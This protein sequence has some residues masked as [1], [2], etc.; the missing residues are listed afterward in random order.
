M[1]KLTDDE[2]QHLT[3]LVASPQWDVVK[4]YLRRV[5]DGERDTLSSTNFENL[6]QVGRSQGRIAALQQL[7]RWVE[8]PSKQKGVS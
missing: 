5:I 6:L 8:A 2:R 1:S 4:S 3:N 7:E